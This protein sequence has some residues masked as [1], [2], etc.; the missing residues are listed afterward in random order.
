[1]EINHTTQMTCNKIIS[2]ALPDK[3][4]C[5]HLPGPVC[6]FVARVLSVAFGNLLSSSSIEK[7]P[8]GFCKKKYE[9]L[10]NRTLSKEMNLSSWIIF[11]FE[12]KTDTY[13]QEQIQNWLIACELHICDR[14]AFF[15]TIVQLHVK[16]V[17]VEVTLYLFVSK[18]DA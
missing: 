6:S 12:G 4:V 2:K 18:V 11:H 10:T 16:D 8:T 17:L 1:M 3:T 14:N 5:G 9:E 13:R 15:R 7:M